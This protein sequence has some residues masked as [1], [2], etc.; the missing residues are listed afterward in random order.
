MSFKFIDPK[1]TI[2]TIILHC[3]ATRAS[4]T[5]SVE[6][7]TSD[8]KAR[9]FDGPGYHAYIRKDGSVVPLRPMTR[10]GA[11]VQDHNTGSFGICFEG[12]LDDKGNPADT[13]TPAQ[14]KAMHEY[15]VALVTFLKTVGQTVTVICGH[16]DFSPDKNGNGKIDPWER[17]KECPCFDAIP[18]FAYAKAG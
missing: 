5:Y 12:G 9:G 17:I 2:H 7:L 4:S 8:H 16:R 15:V 14:K 18:E 10:I 11:H 13:R 3:S 6:Q 1:R